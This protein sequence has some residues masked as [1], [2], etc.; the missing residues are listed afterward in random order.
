M[1]TILVFD[2]GAKA[3]L[4]KL[5]KRFKKACM[6]NGDRDP[7][8]WLE[9]L[10]IYLDDEASWWYDGQLEEVKVSWELLTKGLLTEF[11]ERES[12]QLLTEELNLIKQK[13][14]RKLCKYCTRIEELGACIIRSQRK[15]VRVDGVTEIDQAEMNATLVSI[16]SIILRNVI[17]GLIIVLRDIISWKQPK[18]FEVAFALAQ[19]KETIMTDLEQELLPNRPPLQRIV[20]FVMYHG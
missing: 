19:K 15:T 7:T 1:V 2:R 20:Q 4:K 13:E 18:T 17:R 9:R 11:Q 5:L 6:A 16:Y 10:L 8:S 12:Y 3:D 14:G